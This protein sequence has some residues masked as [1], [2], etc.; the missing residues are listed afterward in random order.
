MKINKDVY[1]K[2]DNSKGKRT[3]IQ[4]RS[5]QLNKEIKSQIK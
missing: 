2:T 5:D 1:T 4:E 3:Q